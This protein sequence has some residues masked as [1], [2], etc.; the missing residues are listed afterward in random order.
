MFFTINCTITTPGRRQ[1]FLQSFRA[2]QQPNYGV[3]KNTVDYINK[4]SYT[5]LI[6]RNNVRICNLASEVGKISLAFFLWIDELR[7]EW[8]KQWMDDGWM[9][10]WMDG[11]TNGYGYSY[12]CG[13]I[14]T[15]QLIQLL[16]KESIQQL[17][18]NLY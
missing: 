3:L 14:S 1:D 4:N 6:I 18:Q 16:L 8:M 2:V 5:K 7:G 10:V 9:Y 11:R 15:L 12:C 13:Y 17:Q